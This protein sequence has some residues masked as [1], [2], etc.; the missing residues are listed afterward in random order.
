M[1]ESLA[2]LLVAVALLVALDFDRG[3]DAGP[4]VAA[5]RARRARRADAQRARPAR[6]RLRRRGV[7]SVRRRPATPRGRCAGVRDRRRGAA[8]TMRRG[9]STTSPGSSARCCCRRTT[10][11]RCSAP[12]A[13]SRTTTTSAAGTSAASARCRTTAVDASVRSAERR[14][15][16]VDY[17]ARPRRPPA[18]SSS[19]PGSGGSLDVYGLASLVALDVG[20]EKAGWAVWAGIV[21]WWLLAVAAVVGWSVLRRGTGIG[22]AL[23]AGRA[24]LAAVLVTTI[25]FYGAHRIRAPAEPVV[26]RARRGRPR[27]RRTAGG[28][29]TQASPHGGSRRGAR[30]T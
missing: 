17:V 4:G 7:A 8:L 27:R 29:A 5:R 20:E 14:D 22:G 18:R 13:T 16:R 10:A 3:A 15:S 12:T 21:A 28:P 24:V 25:L 1:S 26:V 19:P 6:A 23:V 30:S 11:R 2:L 9:S